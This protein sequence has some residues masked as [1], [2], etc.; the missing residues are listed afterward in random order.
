MQI[1]WVVRQALPDGLAV[2]S[3][4][5]LVL[6]ELAVPVVAERRGMTSYHP[7]HIAER[8]GLFTIIVLG[9][10]VL[11]SGN[12][13][14]ESLQDG[15]HIGSLVTVAVGGLAVLA[16]M[17]W[18][19][20]AV[21][22][23]EQLLSFRGSLIWGYSHY[24]LFAAAAAVSSGIEVQVARIGGAAHE[25]VSELVARLSVGVP[26]AVYVLITSA[27]VLRSRL[28]TARRAAAA[29]AAVGLV[30]VSVLPLA[31]GTATALDAAVLAGFVAV[32][33]ASGVDTT[34]VREVR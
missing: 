28:D 22:P 13:V 32:L 19:Y 1:L 16:G 21:D 29:V 6:A 2:A 14:I 3:F 18:V 9:E 7:Q 17:W 10:G 33:V 31:P 34:V 15:K 12:S 25:Q 30:A 8:Y 27:L 20:F 4:L 26:A 24:L 23:A 5:I 11:A